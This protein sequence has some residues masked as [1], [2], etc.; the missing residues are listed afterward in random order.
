MKIDTLNRDTLNRITDRE[1]RAIRWF[2]GV[3]SQVN[4]LTEGA[5]VS[6]G[7]LMD[8]G[9]AATDGGFLL[10]DGGA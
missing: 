7:F 4:N 8:D 9:T 5:S 1:L 2:E 10:D 3:T 6:G